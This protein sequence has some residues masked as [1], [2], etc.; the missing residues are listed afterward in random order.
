[1]LTPSNRGVPPPGFAA[2]SAR[3]R[4]PAEPDAELL[5]LWARFL[6]LLAAGRDLQ[7]EAF[8]PV[9]REMAAIERRLATM[10]AATLE[11]A[12]VLLRVGVLR[13]SCSGK[14]QDR[15]LEGSATDDDPP[16]ALDPVLWRALVSIERQASVSG[17]RQGA[18]RPQNGAVALTRGVDVPPRQP[19]GRGKHEPG[20]RG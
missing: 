5:A 7:D 16:P 12:M 8:D 14:L 6:A 18:A 13:G 3:A 9:S 10:T 1:M 15:Y 20:G 4:E 19:R 11:G 17:G 2:A